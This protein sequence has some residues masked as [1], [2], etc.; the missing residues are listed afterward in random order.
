MI[1]EETLSSSEKLRHELVHHAM[2]AHRSVGHTN[3]FVNAI[4]GSFRREFDASAVE[5]MAPVAMEI[6]SR[7]NDLRRACYALNAERQN[8][9]KSSD[10]RQSWIESVGRALAEFDPTFRASGGV[11]EHGQAVAERTRLLFEGL[12]RRA[13]HQV[14]ALDG[15]I[16]RARV[17]EAKVAELESWIEKHECEDVAGGALDAQAAAETKFFREREARERAEAERDRLQRELDRI[18]A[19]RE[20]EGDGLRGPQPVGPRC[21]ELDAAN[22]RTA[23][24]LRCVS[25]RDETIVSLTRERD[26]L[27]GACERL[28]QNVTLLLSRRDIEREVSRCRAATQAIVECIGSKGEP[29]DLESAIRR[30]AQ[31]IFR[32]RQHADHCDV[33]LQQSKKLLSLTE[34]KA[35]KLQASLEDVS[36]AAKESAQ[37]AKEHEAIAGQFA[38]ALGAVGVDVPAEANRYAV[39]WDLLVQRR[40]LR[41]AAKAWREHFA[42]KDRWG[43]DWLLERAHN[44]VMRS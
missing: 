31:E 40:T 43:S 30:V 15:A 17:A 21:T 8:W 11:V 5:A 35:D 12:H 2:N 18:A 23:D 24:A 38:V 1:D 20:I 37:K 33:Q 19:G 7:Y 4:I 22:E 36:A 25:R 16:E 3:T 13:F 39:R 42:D 10:D 6:S 41:A 29:E 9:L 26:A 27:T 44:I 32:L 34:A 14:A 28:Q